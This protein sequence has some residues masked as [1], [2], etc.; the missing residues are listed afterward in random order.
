MTP[1][2]ADACVN[3]ACI[4][5]FSG[6]PEKAPF[7][8]DKAFRLNPMPPVYY[9]SYLGMTNNLLERYEEAF[10]A[11][12]KGFKINPN[13]LYNRIGLAETY[14]LLGYDDEAHL[15]AEEVLKLHPRFSAKYHISA[16]QYKN[17]ADEERFLNALHKAGLPE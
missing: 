9:Y 10:D 8:L 13:Y 3:F 1:N 15:A 16:M 2:G 11:Y 4:L 5:T 7:W 17:Q 14:S 6:M 12:T